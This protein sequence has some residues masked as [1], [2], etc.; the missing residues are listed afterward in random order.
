M[1][2]KPLGIAPPTLPAGGLGGED[3][4]PAF[5]VPPPGGPV[6]WPSVGRQRGSALLLPPPVGPAP[7]PAAPPDGGCCMAIIFGSGSFAGGR[8]DGTLVVIIHGCTGPSPPS[9]LKSSTQSCST[10][11]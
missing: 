7:F 11:S 4:T 9:A 6:C 5:A 10:N 8:G 1:G 3:A 2:G